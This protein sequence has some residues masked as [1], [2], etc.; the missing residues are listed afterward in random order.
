MILIPPPPRP[1]VPSDEPTS[2]LVQALDLLRLDD[3]EFKQRLFAGCRPEDSRPLSW[4]LCYGFFHQNHQQFLDGIPSSTSLELGA[5]QLSSYLASFGM[6]R[7]AVLRTHNRRLFSAILHSLFEKAR[8]AHINPYVSNG[9]LSVNQLNDLILAVSEGYQAFLS[10]SGYPRPSPPSVTLVS[11]IL[12]GVMGVLP[13]FDTCFKS[14]IQAFNPQAPESCRLSDKLDTASLSALLNV[15]QDPNVQSYLKT[16]LDGVIEVS[17][18]EQN[19]QKKQIQAS[20][21]PMRLLDLYFWS[22]G[23]KGNFK[24]K[25]KTK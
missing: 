6:Y 9:I 5:L 8:N 19:G 13:A 1:I 14:A 16:R 24:N 11:K 10:H 3:A 22:Y 15:V 18:K 12:M 21:P 25:I 7:N 20:Y 2:P 4:D 23:L 17:V